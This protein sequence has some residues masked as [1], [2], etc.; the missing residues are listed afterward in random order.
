WINE[1]GKFR[2]IAQLA[3]AAYS[4]LGA[5]EGSMGVDFSDV[6]GDGRQDIAVT[7][8][9]FEST[10]LYSQVEPLLFKEVSDAAGVGEAARQRLKFGMDFFDID[11]DGDEDL[12]VA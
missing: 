7:N 1:G 9:Q 8:F 3:G 6:N 12:I 5:E 2:D 11:N 10:A 4:N